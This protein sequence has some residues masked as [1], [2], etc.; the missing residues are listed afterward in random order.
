MKQKERKMLG[1]YKIAEVNNGFIVMKDN[2]SG[3][4]STDEWV[5][6]DAE[7]LGEWIKIN[8]IVRFRARLID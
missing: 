1:R 8:G 7:E 5:F 3:W 6:K 2:G 4:A